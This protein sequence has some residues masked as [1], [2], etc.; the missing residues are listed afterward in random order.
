MESLGK[1]GAYLVWYALLLAP[2]FA[3]AWVADKVLE[4]LKPPPPTDIYAPYKE[5]SK[6][7]LA[8]GVVFIVLCALG[9][10]ILT[11]SLEAVLRVACD[12]DPDY[13]GCMGRD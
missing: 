3:A 10:T 7:C 12:G 13:S 9:Y 1:I 5:N 6:G 4:R 8:A 11:P 2:L